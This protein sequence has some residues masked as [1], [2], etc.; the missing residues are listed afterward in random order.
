MALAAWASLERTRH[1][2]RSRELASEA[3]ET[4][5]RLGHDDLAARLGLV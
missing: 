3:L 4:L 5:R 1:P 2:F